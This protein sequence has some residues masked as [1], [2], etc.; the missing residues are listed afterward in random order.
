MKTTKAEAECWRRL[1]V[2]ANNVRV[3]IVRF[4]L[5]SEIASLSE[6][7]DKL[8]AN[9]MSISPPG[10]FKHMVIL[11]DAGVVRKESGAFLPSPDA[12]KT[13]YLLEGKKRVENILKS[14]ESDVSKLLFAGET[15]NKTARLARKFQG[16]GPRL[17]RD[18][19]KRLES[20]L[21]LCE[22]ETVYNLLTED[23]RKKVKLWR[24]LM[25]L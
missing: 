25:T 7:A 24:I 2:F 10:L 16:I 1:H 20:L 13:I 4:L 22:E 23:E 11:E 17:L 8:N 14:L 9:G 19:R 21:N 6:I 15:F 12:R 18:E 5:Q 3:E